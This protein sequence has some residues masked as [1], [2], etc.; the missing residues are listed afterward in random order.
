MTIRDVVPVCFIRYAAAATWS[1]RLTVVSGGCMTS[2]AVAAAACG[3]NGGF[4]VETLV[5]TCSISGL[6][7]CRVVIMLC[8]VGVGAFTRPLAVFWSWVCWQ[9]RGLPTRGGW[10]GGSGLEVAVDQGDG[11]GA[12]A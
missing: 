6:L 11:G 4:C 5:I 7:T 8:S 2:A 9:I 3:S 1:C 10:R 12:F